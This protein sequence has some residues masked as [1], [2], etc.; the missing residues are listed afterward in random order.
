MFFN[1]LVEIFE[2]HIQIGYLSYFMI[3]FFEKMCYNYKNILWRF[4]AQTQIANKI[5]LL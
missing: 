5:K 2:K 3:D 4:L 1:C